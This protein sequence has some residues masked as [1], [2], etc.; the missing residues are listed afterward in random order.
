MSNKKRNIIGIAILLIIA[1]I[2]IVVLVVSCSKKEKSDG[3]FRTTQELF[4]SQ[5]E[6]KTETQVVTC[7]AV[8]NQ[9]GEKVTNEKGEAVTKKS[10]KKKEKTTNFWDSISV[11]EDTKPAKETEPKT[12]KKGET[13]TEAYPGANDGWSPIVSPDDLKKD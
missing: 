8:T 5:E 13:V 9:K 12:N 10:K 4:T 6:S 7:E 1:V 2:I 11:Y 3:M